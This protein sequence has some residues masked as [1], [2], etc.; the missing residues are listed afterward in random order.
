MSK[1]FGSRLESLAKYNDEYRGGCDNC[2]FLIGFTVLSAI[3]LVLTAVLLK[4][5]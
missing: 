4:Y 3:I 1:S 2:H 5:C